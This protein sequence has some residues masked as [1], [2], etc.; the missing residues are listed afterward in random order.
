MPGDAEKAVRQVRSAANEMYRAVD[1][2]TNFHGLRISP[3][4]AREI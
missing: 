3:D 1:A 4:E 2:I